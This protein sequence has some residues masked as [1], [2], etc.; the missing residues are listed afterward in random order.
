MVNYSN[1]HF[2]RSP[3]HLENQKFGRRPGRSIKISPELSKN[4]LVEV[5]GLDFLSS[6]YHA[7]AAIQRLLTATNY[8]GNTKGV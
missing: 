1:C 2:I 3:I 5:I 8:K 4:G 7:L 6:H